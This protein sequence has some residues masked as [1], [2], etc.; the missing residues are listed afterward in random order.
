MRAVHRSPQNPRQSALAKLSTRKKT[1]TS[2]YFYLTACVPWGMLSRMT[3][4]TGLSAPEWQ[5]TPLLTLLPQ[6]V[7][8]V[9]FFN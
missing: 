1:D 7:G 8:N 9:F 3:G 5:K 2:L 4:I 6:P